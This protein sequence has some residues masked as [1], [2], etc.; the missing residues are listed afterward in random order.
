MNNIN[1]DGKVSIQN[2]DN[3]IQLN[4]PNHIVNNMYHGIISMFL[5]VS[6]G[7]FFC[8]LPAS[9][10]YIHLGTGNTLTTNSTT[11]SLETEIVTEPNIKQ[12]FIDDSVNG[13][14]T[15]TYRCIW[16]SGVITDHIEEIG[17]F[18][19]MDTT[20]TGS[21]SVSGNF[22]PPVVL[23]SR[24]ASADGNFTQLIPNSNYPITIDWILTLSM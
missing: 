22:T 9:L 20:R 18:M 7:T 6:Y 17:L 13:Q 19:R 11:T 2:G 23:A 12:I 15:I 10:W 14:Y 5:M 24:L 1:I 21:Y 16:G 3:N 4:I 8:Y